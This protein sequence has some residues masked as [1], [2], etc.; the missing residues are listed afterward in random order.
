M[1]VRD[2]SGK[3]LGKVH[4]VYPWGFEVVRGFWSPYQWVFRHDEVI[5]LDGGTVEV[6]RR[7]DDLQRLAAG[8]LPET[9]RR[10]PLPFGRADVPSAPAEAHAAEAA[11][12]SGLQSVAPSP[13]EERRSVETRGQAGAATS[14]VAA[15]GNPHR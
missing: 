2:A 10:Q 5:R 9:W 13:E 11:L 4:R 8:E 7:Q 1:A 14:P 12:H 6:A 3:R 15:T